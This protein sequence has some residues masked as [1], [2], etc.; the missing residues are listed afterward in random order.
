M[1]SFEDTLI[2]FHGDY[3]INEILSSTGTFP[4]R[5]YYIKGLFLND[6]F[7]YGDVSLADI[8]FDKD[9]K[10][11]EIQGFNTNNVPVFK[12]SLVC[13]EMPDGNTGLDGINPSLGVGFIMR[14]NTFSDVLIENKKNTRNNKE[15]NN[16]LAA[17]SNCFISDGVKRA[18]IVCCHD[19]TNDVDESLM[20][21]ELCVMGNNIISDE[22]LKKSIIECPTGTA[23]ALFNKVK[24]VKTYE[25]LFKTEDSNAGMRR[26]FIAQRMEE[27][28]PELVKKTYRKAHPVRKQSNNQWIDEDDNIIDTNIHSIEINQEHPNVGFFYT[29]KNRTNMCIDNIGLLEVMWVT[30]QKLIEKNETLENRVSTL[31]GYY[32][33]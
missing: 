5:T 17:T 28:F 20:V 9:W 1:T 13:R 31:E 18:G 4:N 30:I 29:T 10:K 7:K 26:G 25:Y 15:N 21:N 11:Y 3:E 24:S 23:S 6:N 2:S 22:N 27:Q 19:M 33:D 32:S 8:L 12:R 14:S 16:F